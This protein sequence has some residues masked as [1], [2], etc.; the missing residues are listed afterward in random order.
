MNVYQLLS[1]IMWDM[2]MN[3]GF[4]FDQIRAKWLLLEVRLEQYVY[5]K[6][7]SHP[8][9]LTTIAWYGARFIGSIFQWFL[10]NSNIPG[11][12]RIGRGLRLPHPQNIII[13]R[14]ADIGEFCIIYHNVS[15]S[16]NA[17]KPV[18][19]SSPKIGD[20]VLIGNS[21]IV[22]G[23]VTVGD[24]VLIGAGAI[25]AKSVPN[26]SRVISAPVDVATRLP[27]PDAAEAG[28][29]RHLSDPYSV[30]R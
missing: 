6:M 11:S 15:I 20:R 17:F 25:V 30:W 10:C 26:N 27:S 9:L 18:V 22:I 4:S 19:P 3:S 21:A 24:N 23:D 12:V 5:H 8:G 28:S 13:A 29:E 14:M 1:L 7:Q 2:R 16:W